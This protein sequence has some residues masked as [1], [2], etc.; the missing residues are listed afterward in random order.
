[1]PKSAASTIQEER[2]NTKWSFARTARVT[3]SNMSS[4]YSSMGVKVRLSLA[5]ACEEMVTYIIEQMSERTRTG[6]LSTQ[7]LSAALHQNPEL[8][9]LFRSVSLVGLSVD[10]R[11][12]NAS[13]VRQKRERQTRTVK[14]YSRVLWNEWK[15]RNSKTVAQ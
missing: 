8:K 12:P 9:A 5:V 3:K 13:E 15:Q 4:D 1:M 10:S 11:A 7:A 2:L 14:A 6:R